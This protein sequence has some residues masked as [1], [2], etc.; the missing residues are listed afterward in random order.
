LFDNI[1]E[2]DIN[3]VAEPDV[4]YGDKDERIIRAKKAIKLDEAIKNAREASWRGNL[5]KERKIRRAIKSV[6]GNDESLI[7]TIFEIVKQ[8]HEY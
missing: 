1:N 8:Q 7:D 2:I 3:Y 4:P 5:F 6:L